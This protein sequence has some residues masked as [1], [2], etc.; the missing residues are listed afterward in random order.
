[1]AGWLDI[2]WAWYH[3]MICGIVFFKEHLNE[4]LFFMLQCSPADS[5]VSENTVAKCQRGDKHTGHLVITGRLELVDPLLSRIQRA[6]VGSF[7]KVSLRFVHKVKINVILYELYL[8]ICCRSLDYL[9][10]GVM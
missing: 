10:V 9:I 1:M 7:E 2:G 3:A 8:L 4:V 5:K 6:A